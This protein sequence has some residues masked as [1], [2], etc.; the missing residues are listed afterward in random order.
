MTTRFPKLRSFVASVIALAAV[1][2]VVPAAGSQ[3]DPNAQP[4][5]TEAPAPPPPA[6]TLEQMFPGIPPGTTVEQ[7]LFFFMLV[8]GP[9]VPAGSGEGRRIV[10]SN[11]QQRVWLVEADGSVARTYLVSGRRGMPRVGLY[12]VFSK[13]R[14]TSSGSARMEFMV[15]FARGRRLA[16]GFH[17]IPTRANGTP[18]Q[19]QAQLGIPMSHGCVRQKPEDAVFLYFWAPVGTPVVAMP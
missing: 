4:P 8:Q 11:S 15:R 1:L 13:S 17:T 14:H 10:Y 19:S 12:R 18:L 2:T 7:L 6:P 3:T 16:I 5:T 9:P